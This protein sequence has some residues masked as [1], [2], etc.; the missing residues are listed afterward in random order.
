MSRGGAPDLKQ[1]MD[2]ELS[3]KLNGNRTVTGTLRGFDQFMNIVLDGGSSALPS[4]SPPSF[5][6]SPCA[7][8]LPSHTETDYPCCIAKFS[9]A[10]L[11]H[12][13]PPFFRASFFEAGRT[14]GSVRPCPNLFGFR[15]TL[16]TVALAS[17]VPPRWSHPP[18]R[19]R[20][21]WWPV[22]VPSPPPTHTRAVA[23]P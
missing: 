14:A 2:K 23:P 7:R 12:Q 5:F 22:R 19:I 1:Y 20:S 21:G 4:F 8:L 13:P 17:Q 11:H 9:V 6:L 3:L 16:P 18:R 15:R 10:A